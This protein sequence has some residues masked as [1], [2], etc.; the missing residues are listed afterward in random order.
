MCVD[1]SVDLAVNFIF[2]LPAELTNTIDA[3]IC[4]DWCHPHMPI[5]AADPAASGNRGGYFD[6]TKSSL[7]LNNFVMN[8]SFTV[9]IGAKITK[10]DV[11]LFSA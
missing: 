11:S 2:S 1:S 6:G 9:N 8:G 3:L 4:A 7:L 5:P 10:K